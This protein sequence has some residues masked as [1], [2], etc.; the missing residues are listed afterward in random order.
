MNLSLTMV[1]VRTELPFRNECI[2]N[3]CD[4]VNVN[5]LAANFSYIFIDS[6]Y[7]Y[8]I[9]LEFEVF[10]RGN[11][12]I[13]NSLFTKRETYEETNLG[14]ISIKT[15]VFNTI[16]SIKN[17]IFRDLKHRNP[18]LSAVNVY[19][20]SCELYA[21]HGVERS[22]MGNATVPVIENCTFIRNE[23]ALSLQYN[24][25]LVIVSD[26]VF[27]SNKVWQA[28]GAIRVA[29][30]SLQNRLLL[31][32]CIFKNNSAGFHDFRE[33]RGLEDTIKV[34]NDRV[35]LNSSQ[36][37][38]SLILAGKGG[39]LRI[40]KGT[41]KL[42][43]CSFF[44]N[45]STR[46]GGTIYL[47]RRG[48]IIISFCQ[49]RNSPV[50]L[51]PTQGDLI[52]SNGRV[53]ISDTKFL[54][55]TAQQHIDI[56]HLT[57]EYWSIDVRSL[58]FTCPIGHKLLIVNA[59]SSKIKQEG[60]MTSHKLDQL[61]YTCKICGDNRYSMSRGA[62]IYNASKNGT[63]D[64]APYYNL[65]VDSEYPNG[66]GLTLFNLT[67]I[68]PC[69]S[70]P[71][72]GDCASEIRAIPNYWGYYYGNRI[73]FLPC[74]PNYCCS[75]PPCQGIQPCSKNR[76]GR[77]CGQCAPGYSEAFFSTTCVKNE[78]CSKWW[79]WILT[80]VIKIVYIF[81]FSVFLIYQGD[82]RQFLFKTPAFP[83]RHTCCTE[84]I[85]SRSRNNLVTS[86]TQYKYDESSRV[87]DCQLE[88]LNRLD[89]SS[90]KDSRERMDSD[91]GNELE[92]DSSD[93]GRGFLV[94]LFYYFQD[95]WLLHI[96]TAYTKTDTAL[97]KQ[98]KSLLQ[99]IFRFRLDNLFHFLEVVLEHMCLIKDLKPVQKALI[100]VFDVPVILLTFLVL[101]I[102]NK[103]CS[104]Q[105]K[106]QD[107]CRRDKRSAYFSTRLSTGFILLLL[108]TYQ[109]LATTIF[110]LVHCVKIG[111]DSVLFLDG[112]R[113]CYHPWQYFAMLYAATCLVPFSLV[114]MFG[115]SLLA[116]GSISLTNFFFA[117]LLPGPFL[118]YWIYVKLSKRRIKKLKRPL[119]RE[120][121]AVLHFLQRPFVET[122]D[123][124][125]KP[126]RVC[127][128]GLL[129]G[130]RLLLIIS[131]T[132]ITNVLYRILIM[133]AV[134]FAILM[135]HVHW[136]PY[137]SSQGNA[138]GTLS[139]AT[140][141]IVAGINLVRAGFE[142][143]EYK[144]QGPNYSLM[145][146]FDVVENMLVLWLPLIG[147]CFTLALI[148]LR[149]FCFLIS[150]SITKRS[151]ATKT[152]TQLS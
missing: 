84:M 63:D 47:D 61:I 70:C 94:I 124:V 69:Y 19:D 62:L 90:I 27:I 8:N 112:V 5:A 10:D 109:K 123:Q 72:G 34:V 142:S 50:D 118:L 105:V 89:S 15:T 133:L 122:I 132:F 113:D 150:R 66:T 11:L 59:T 128:A 104:R 93:Q 54:V 42:E 67:D 111:G 41:I 79:P 145:K 71:Y 65:R 14:G 45:T 7:F 30:N 91:N 135:H 22:V 64:I 33:M 16:I 108:I 106:K 137:G 55:L 35:Q 49:F 4:N 141:I 26:C 92:Y 120:A 88:S 24:F 51:H 98:L 103:I 131:Y 114:L 139:A 97:E 148:V 110:S 101:F 48:K 85:R 119:S 28:G 77:L 149:F 56:L 23:R 17:C 6:S 12:S 60:L 86:N 140:L 152:Q 39:A 95:A 117:S 147:V 83:S 25:G 36:H 125:A 29:L 121:Y 78:N 143:A 37:K 76:Q 130:R 99:G 116:A 32:N 44:N 52:Y 21:I 144:P 20:A 31:R 102:I 73:A 40:H 151:T 68:E 58:N 38:G 18:I 3:P 146:V 75:I 115:P 80:A 96:H 127:W 82:L 138:A 13:T 126:G 9:R 134:C 53:F 107:C 1:D 129:T 46:L 43:N 74:P 81:I 87:E 57:G 100:K 2:N 136:Q